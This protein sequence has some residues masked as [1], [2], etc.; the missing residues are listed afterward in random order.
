VSSKHDW[1]KMIGET[2]ESTGAAKEA[3]VSNALALEC[4]IAQGELCVDVVGAMPLNVVRFI[5]SR[6]KS[7]VLE[8]EAHGLRFKD[9]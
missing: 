4:I 8:F 7:V 1:E 5:N 6:S 9:V 3:V 2:K